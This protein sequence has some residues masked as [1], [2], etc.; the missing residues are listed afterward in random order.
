LGRLADLPEPAAPPA[1]EPTAAEIRAW[2]RTAGLDV[3]S[4]GRIPGETRQA[5]HHAHT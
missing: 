4:G 5:Y 1:P 3:S 2:A